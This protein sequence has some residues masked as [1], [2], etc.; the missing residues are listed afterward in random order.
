M[1]RRK[2][3]RNYKHITESLNKVKRSFF[4]HSEIRK[5]ELETTLMTEHIPMAGMLIQE[6][7]KTEELRSEK[8]GKSKRYKFTGTEPIYIG[9]VENCYK[10]IDEKI[11]GYNFEKGKKE[12]RTVELMSHEDAIEEAIKVLKAEGYRILRSRIEW[13][14]I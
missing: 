2:R 6:L 4:G 12:K 8:E 7:E 5:S 11:K 10:N 1:T 3:L 14:E 13:E 9:I